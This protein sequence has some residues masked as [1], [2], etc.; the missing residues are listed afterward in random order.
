M[1]QITPKSIEWLETQAREA[2]SELPPGPDR[3]ECM[4]YWM[5]MRHPEVRRQMETEYPV[6]DP[7]YVRGP[8]KRR[9]YSG[10]RRRRR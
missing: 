9:R 8:R 10:Y 4:D 2:C 5:L 1:R 7:V 6:Y 3:N